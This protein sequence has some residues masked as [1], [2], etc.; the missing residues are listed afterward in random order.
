MAQHDYDIANASGASVRA[1]INAVLLAIITQNS[2]DTEPLEKYAFM[3]WAQ[4][5]TGKLFLRNG[6]N[7]AWNEIGSLDTANLG[8][9]T[10]ADPTLT[11]EPKAPTAGTTT[12]TTQIATTAF[13]QAAAGAKVDAK[14]TITTTVDGTETTGRSVYINNSA[15]ASGDG[16]NGDIWFE[17]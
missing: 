5:S 10:L 4:P 16:A 11:G 12:S 14:K 2:G 6:S 13:V 3:C 15:P 9:A 17:Y 8:L 7:T 1:D